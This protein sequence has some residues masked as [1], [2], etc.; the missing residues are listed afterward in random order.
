MLRPESLEALEAVDGVL[1]QLELVAEVA[2]RP[3]HF[4]V[5]SDHGQAQG[6][7]FADRYGE[8]LGALVSRLA[9]A[10][11]TVVRGRHRG[12]GP[13]PGARRRARGGRG[14][15]S[16]APCGTSPAAMERGDDRQARRTAGLADGPVAVRGDAD[17]AD[18]PRLRLGQPRA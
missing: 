12:L 4:V 1:R 14:V 17:G 8:E 18:L 15:R 10:D 2:P 16:A 7:T 5:L 13:H 9:R 11:V 3:Y 6:A